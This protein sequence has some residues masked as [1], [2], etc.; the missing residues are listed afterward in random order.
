VVVGQSRNVLLVSEC[1]ILRW[2]SG[3]YSWTLELAND[4]V[5]VATIPVASTSFSTSMTYLRENVA[6]NMNL[7]HK[8]TAEEAPEPSCACW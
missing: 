2:A 4:V 8:E 6:R 7:C 5:V 1:R 3:W